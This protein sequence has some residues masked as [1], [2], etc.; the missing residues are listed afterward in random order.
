MPARV[1][2]GGPRPGELV[3]DAAAPGLSARVRRHGDPSARARGG[4]RD[5]APGAR[6]CGRRSPGA[7]SRAPTRSASCSTWTCS[8]CSTR[9][10]AS[11][12]GRRGDRRFRSRWAPRTTPTCARCCSSG[13]VPRAPDDFRRA[14]A[15]LA[16]AVHDRAAV[17]T[18]ITAVEPSVGLEPFVVGAILGSFAFAWRK[19]APEHVPVGPGRA[20]RP[21]RRRPARPGARGRDRRGEL[22][23]PHARLGAVQPQE[24]RLARRPGGRAGRRGRAR[25]SRSGTRSGWPTKGSAASSASARPR[26]PRRGWSGSTTRRPKESRRRRPR[27]CWSARASPSTPAACRSSPARRWST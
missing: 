20:G 3:A 7:R 4:G 16:R 27:S 15:T 14:G 18:T 24:P 13:S 9:T 26:R 17:A 8:R 5:R 1:S 25:R 12:Q 23:G 10:A 6:G 22:A 11:R 2:L 21:G 19:A